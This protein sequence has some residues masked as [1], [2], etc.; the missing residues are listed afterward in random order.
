MKQTEIMKA[1][2]L[3]MAAAAALCLSSCDGY[4]SNM[5]IPNEYAPDINVVMGDINQYPSLVK[6][7]YVNYWQY[8]LGYDTEPSWNMSTNADIFT[9]S[10]GNWDMKT[11][12]YHYSGFEKPELANT[13][14]SSSAPK[15]RWYN[16][17]SII[18]TVR[19]MLS[20][21]NEGDLVYTEGGK[22]M[23]FKLYAN[24]Y[25]LL[26]IAY[27]E[28]ALCFDK[29]FLL[30]ENT[31]VETI[32]KDDIRPSSEIRDAALGYLDKC[33]DICRNNT[34]SNF[35]GTFPGNAVGDNTKLMQVANFMAA[36]LLAYYPRTNKA[37]TP[38]WKKVLEYARNA[39]TED[40]CA[41]MPANEATYG[42]WSQ[43]VAGYHTSQWVRPSMRIIAMMAPDDKG[44]VW[45]IPK[46]YS[47][48]KD[49][50]MPK[51]VNCPDA[52]LNNPEYFVYTDVVTTGSG[53]QFNNSYSSYYMGEKNRFSLTGQPSGEG[54]LYL[55]TKTESDLIYAEALAN[56]GKLA[57][58]AALVNL[59]HKNV[60]G[61]TD[62]DASS[63]KD[64]IIESVYYEMFVECCFASS[65]TGWYNR[66]RT[67]VDKFQ[68]TTRSYRE[69]PVP[70]VEIDFYGL[71]D[72]TFGGP[73][74]E[75]KEYQF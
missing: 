55:F 40:I 34:F 36:R 58:A 38:D 7:A 18:N 64:K 26:G 2:T 43:A 10:A 54:T 69:L 20:K 6:G 17:Y 23:N 32:T 59:T 46:D 30:T 39:L 11:Y 63:S 71:E 65:A 47:F 4:F 19:S 41:E 49:G 25:F 29:C 45:P 8:M 28:M 12:Y 53:A 13:D 75:Y 35:D 24:N 42:C 61:M 66:R 52:R 57:E 60:G 9:P 3:V 67:P 16:F 72:Y 62:I 50:P 22:D 37:D 5:D 56:N 74:D 31:D 27:A 1:K 15:A 14:P 68:L 44:A 51:V 48:A 21:M 70:K 73:R 33:I